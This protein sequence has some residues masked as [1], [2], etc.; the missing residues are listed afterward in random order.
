MK[1]NNNNKLKKM[2]II[3]E[4]LFFSFVFTSYTNS[5]HYSLKIP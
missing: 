1:Y 4:K 5:K 3:S 2:K